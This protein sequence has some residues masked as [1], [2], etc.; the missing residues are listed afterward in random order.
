MGKQAKDG[1]AG[2][3]TIKSRL[4]A[5]DIKLTAIQFLE[6]FTTNCSIYEQ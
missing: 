3:R 6:L 2:M 4:C 1:S 5:Q